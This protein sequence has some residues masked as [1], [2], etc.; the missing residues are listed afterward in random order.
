MA[1]TTNGIKSAVVAAVV[2]TVVGG[3]ITWIGGWLPALWELTTAGAAWLW[4]YLAYTVPVPLAILALLALPWVV[5]C[6]V[7]IG[8]LFEK[9]ESH[10][11]SITTPE[12]PLGE[13][14]LQLL[15]LLAR[16]DGLL[17]HFDDAASHLHT[18]RLLLQRACE[19]LAGRGYIEP[20]N[21]IVR[22]LR[23]GLT[24]AGTDFVIQEGFPLGGLRE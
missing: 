1:R 9:K 6:A 12:Q 17:V 13:L 22:G 7:W 8:S 3:I 23:I 5:L 18:S 14:E 15:R 10:A 2:T 19:S 20:H 4:S 24:R 21:H 11:P 16:A